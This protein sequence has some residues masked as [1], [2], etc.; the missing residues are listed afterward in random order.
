MWSSEELLRRWREWVARETDW[1]PHVYEGWRPLAIDL[2]AFWRPRLQGWAARF[3]HQVAQRLMPGVAFAVVV[4]VGHITRQRVPLLRKLIRGDREGETEA[5]LKGRLLAWVRRH[6]APDQV[7]ICDGGVE[8]QQMQAA[9]VPRFVL[10]M[11]KNCALRRNVL[12]PPEAK[13]GRPREYGARVRPLARKYRGRLIAASQPDVSGSFTVI[14]EQNGEAVTVPFHGWHGLVRSD[15]KVAADNGPARH[16]ET[17]SIW[18]FFDP[19]YRDPLV[20]ATNIAASP[21]AIYQLYGDRWP[22]EQPPLAAKQ[23]LGLHR[24][25]VFAPASIWRLP[26]LALLLGNVLTIAATLLPPL[27]SGYWDRRPK[28]RPAGYGERWQA[29]VFQTLT[30]LTGEFEKRPLIRPIC[31][32]ALRPTAAFRGCFQHPDGLFQANFGPHC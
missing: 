7:A 3:F 13:G 15:Q 29:P 4:E 21:E 17:V 10:R 30:R 8:L 25:F 31:R 18:V 9:G 12:P 11:A 14:D 24:H 2:T 1:Q 23:M 26:E 32:R 22:V 16:A 28:K 19:R 6:L 20:L 27:P 5:T